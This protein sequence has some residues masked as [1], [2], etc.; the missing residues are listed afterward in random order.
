MLRGWLAVGAFAWLGVACGD[1]S[2][3]AGGSGQGG[4]GGGVAG[5]TTGGG[6][7]GGEGG[8]GPDAL[9]G[10]G[11]RLRARVRDG[12]GG[13][14][15]FISWF[16]TELGFDCTFARHA[17][18]SLRCMPPAS[19]IARYADPACSQPLV[20]QGTSSCNDN[21]KHAFVA[22]TGSDVCEA[23]LGGNAQVSQARRLYELG[24][25]VMPA[26]TYTIDAMG[27]CV[28]GGSMGSGSYF[29]LGEEVD[30]ASLA[31]ATDALVARGPRAQVRVIEGDDGSFEVRSI[32][33]AELGTA[34][35]P[36]GHPIK[37]CAPAFQA[38]LLGG[39]ADAACTQEVAR[40]PE[41]GCQS[42]FFVRDS[43]PAPNECDPATTVYRSVGVEVPDDQVH[44][45]SFN[46]VPI[47]QI[48]GDQTLERYIFFLPGAPLPD[49]S[50]F[51][52][53]D[54]AVGSG[55][56]AAMHVGLPSG[57]LLTASGT[58]FDNERTR[59]CQLA[60]FP[61]GTFRCVALGATFNPAS[62][63]YFADAGC[64][65]PL[66]RRAVTSC[67]APLPTLWV[68]APAECDLPD[69][70]HSFPSV[71]A[72]FAAEP[73]KGQVFSAASGTCEAVGTGSYEYFR[74]AP[75][76]TPD[77]LPLIEIVTE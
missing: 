28:V 70:G 68:Q 9:F 32:F 41:S 47:E 54:V 52:V 44:A 63:V 2:P 4:D 48:E 11:S 22:E 43:T 8:E 25:E 72:V 17:G 67:S 30:A 74:P 13:A 5:A 65:E 69:P 37:R 46:C 12:G 24:T 1:D 57:E 23:T 10:S 50:Y 51:P 27:A 73:F 45:S 49:D 18:G 15:Q 3:S 59:S 21:H 62:A 19:A 76:V 20:F 6:G 77:Q 56:L 14:Q 26:D 42:P 34:C 60:A 64:S 31:G 16:D 39:Y 53:A 71:A 66:Y 58:W 75:E 29:V 55:S 35:V 33:D 38:E 7:E 40:Q 61:D 36:M